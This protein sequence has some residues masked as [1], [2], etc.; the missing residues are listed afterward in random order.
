MLRLKRGTHSLLY[1]TKRRHKCHKLMRTVQIYTYTHSLNSPALLENG[2]MPG[3]WVC[4]GSM[5]EETFGGVGKV[6]M[7]AES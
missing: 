6:G 2:L 5:V 7:G 3:A 4:D 1:G